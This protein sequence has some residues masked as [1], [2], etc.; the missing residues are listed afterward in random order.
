MWQ[1]T[2]QAFKELE[3]KLATILSARQASRGCLTPINVPENFVAQLSGHKNTQSLQSYKSAN[4]HHQRQMSNTLSRTPNMSKDAQAS[5]EQ[6]MTTKLVRQ[7]TSSNA[8]AVT[9]AS[10]HQL[11]SASDINSRA[12]FAGANKQHSVLDVNSKSSLGQ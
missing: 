11:Q 4:E 7:S 9:Q 3:Q 8:I 2:T 10:L 5:K 6:S 12:V 1:Q